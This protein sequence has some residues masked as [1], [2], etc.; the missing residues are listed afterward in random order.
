MSK[1]I[2]I[3]DVQTILTQPAGS[4]LVVVKV[5]TSEPGLYGLGCAT[6]TQRFH[7]VHAA[8]EKHLKPFAIGRDVA[9]I[10]EFY[11]MATVHSYWRN[12]PVLNNAISGI[13]QALWDIKGKLAGMPV[14]EL[15]GGKCR[16]AAAVYV[17]ADG[18]DPQEVEDNVRRFLAQGYRYIRVQ[19]GGYGG[20]HSILFSPEGSPPGHYYDPRAYVRNMLQMIEHV[21]AQVGP[22][23]ELLHDIHERLQ[24]IDAVRF[25][26]AVEP[27]HLFFLEDPLAP[28]DIEWFARIREQCATPLAMGELFNNPREWQPLIAGKLIDFVRMH[29]SQMGGITPA[30]GVALFAQMY[31]VRTAWHGPGDTSPVGHAANLHLDL[32]S[33]NF[34]IQEWCRFP[35]VVYE[36]FPGLPQVRDGYMYPNERPGLGIDIDEKLASQFPCQDEVEFWTQTRWPD[37]SPARP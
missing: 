11:R 2:T 9:R 8:I 17:H 16:E 22:E 32:W 12:G 29:V 18:R 25:A 37:G 27:Y 24:P 14:Y 13:D 34:G 28:E 30:R 36:M 5:L 6:F 1:P 20:Q 35:E 4:R 21:R 15:L 10:E 19:M 33:P 3:R 31:G 26:K 23:V 7:A